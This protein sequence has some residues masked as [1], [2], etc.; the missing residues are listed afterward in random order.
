MKLFAWLFN[1]VF[2]WRRPTYEEWRH[3]P[4]PAWGAKRSGRDYW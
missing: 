3:G 1:L 2:S 4:N